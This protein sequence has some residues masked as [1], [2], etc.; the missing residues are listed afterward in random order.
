MGVNIRL[1]RAGF[2]FYI[3]VQVFINQAASMMFRQHVLLDLTD[4]VFQ[5]PVVQVH[6]RVFFRTRCGIDIYIFKNIADC[7]HGK[8]LM[9]QPPFQDQFHTCLLSNGF[10]D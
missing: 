3:K 9:F 6:F 1:A 5:F 4:I 2:H 10:P 8:L 7:V